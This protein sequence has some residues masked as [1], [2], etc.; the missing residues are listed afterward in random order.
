MK[1][2]RESEREG[3]ERERERREGDE[4][5]RDITHIFHYLKF[6]QV[7]SLSVHQFSDIF[8]SFYLVLL[9]VFEQFAL[10]F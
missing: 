2:E 1:K 10:G 6:L 5:I 8:L 4:R 7:C 9:H 3:V